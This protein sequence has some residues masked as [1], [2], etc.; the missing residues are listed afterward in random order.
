M[1]AKKNASNETGAVRVEDWWVNEEIY[2]KFKHYEKH[3]INYKEVDNA[4]F[5][6]SAL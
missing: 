4:D 2:N 3:D 1:G 6:H 5:I